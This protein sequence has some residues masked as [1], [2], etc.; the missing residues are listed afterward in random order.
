MAWKDNLLDA[1]FRG[2]R[3]DCVNTGDSLDRSNAEHAFPYK[4]GAKMEDLG[5]GAQRFHIEAVF[6]GDDYETR[7]QAFLKALDEGGEGDLVHPILGSLKVTVLHREVRH[8][9]EEVDMCHVPVDFAESKPGATLFDRSLSVQKASSIGSFAGFSRLAGLSLLTRSVSRL[10][11]TLHS[12]DAIRDT[13]LDVAG[14]L[15]SASP[16]SVL[17]GLDVITDPQAWA[18]DMTSI[19]TGVVDAYSWSGDSELSDWRSSR[20]TTRAAVS[21]LDDP[22]DADP[23]ME[24][25][26]LEQAL[27]SAAAAQTV[28]EAEAETPTLSPSEIEEV[29]GGAREDLE[30]AIETYRANH[31]IEES[32]PVTEPLKDTALAVQQAA[33][34]VI[35]ARPPLVSRT[36]EAPGNLRLIAH[37]WYGDHGR[38]QELYRLNRPSNPN[39]LTTGDRLNAYVQ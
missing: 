17:S 20:A 16:R 32:R 5:A 38:A 24:Y 39:A 36:L 12:T 1:S 31:G 26:G 22:G 9:A 35:E 19:F 29:A 33:Q 18:A 23:V 2:V 37:R 4:D 6:F 34:A 10:K 28:L 11:R 30:E 13:S 3:F 25:V 27:S 15:R 21:G 14:S 8:Q 7:L